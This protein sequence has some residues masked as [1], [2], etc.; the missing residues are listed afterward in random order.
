MVGSKIYQ[1][2]T[3][4]G[5]FKGNKILKLISTFLVKLHIDDVLEVLLVVE[6]EFL[7]YETYI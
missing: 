6:V 2:A 1:N 7:S 3:K 4:K 5:R